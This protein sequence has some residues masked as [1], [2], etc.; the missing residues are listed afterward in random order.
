MTLLCLSSRSFVLHSFN[1]EPAFVGHPQLRNEQQQSSLEQS[2]RCCFNNKSRGAVLFI[3]GCLLGCFE[4]TLPP[5]I[6]CAGG[7]DFSIVEGVK[8]SGPSLVYATSS[9]AA[10]GIQSTLQRLD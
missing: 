6:G 4:S 3:A 1:R 10:L 8:R 9:P 2:N 5:T 7:H